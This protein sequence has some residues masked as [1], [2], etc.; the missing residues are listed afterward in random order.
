MKNYGNVLRWQW[1]GAAAVQHH[2]EMTKDPLGLAFRHLTQGTELSHAFR[3]EVRMES[4]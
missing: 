2:T 3:N 1:I 4:L